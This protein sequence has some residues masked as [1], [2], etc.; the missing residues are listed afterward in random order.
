MSDVGVRVE[1]STDLV[2]WLWNNDA[3]G[4]VWTIETSVEPR[5]DDSHW[6]TVTAALVSPAQVFYRLRAVGP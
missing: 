2:H 4:S 3:P 1:I 5:D 6:V